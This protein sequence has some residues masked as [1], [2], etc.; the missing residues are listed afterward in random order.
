M[1]IQKVR[2]SSMCIYFAKK[3]T[4]VSG[5]GMIFHCRGN[6][7]EL[8]TISDMIVYRESCG[9]ALH[10]FSFSFLQ[11]SSSSWVL[12]ATVIRM[13]CSMPSLL[14]LEVSVTLLGLFKR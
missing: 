12:C 2:Q 7:P 5:S 4:N 3:V 10:L 13:E 11:N 1:C 8:A 9:N 14:R 6:N